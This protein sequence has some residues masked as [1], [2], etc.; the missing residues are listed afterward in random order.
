MIVILSR[1]GNWITRI[2]PNLVSVVVKSHSH[3]IIIRVS[4]G[5]QRFKLGLRV[6]FHLDFNAKELDGTL[7]KLPISCLGSGNIPLL[8]CNQNMRVSCKSN[9]QSPR[10]NPLH[11]HLPLACIC[12]TE[13]PYNKGDDSSK[14]TLDHA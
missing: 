7:F 14:N 4:N 5:A 6:D 9:S 3:P 1:H 13:V 10:H 8:S 12:A 2:F 11:Q